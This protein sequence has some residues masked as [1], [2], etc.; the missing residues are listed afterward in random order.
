M[1]TFNLGDGLVV[2]VVAMIVV[3]AVLAS[4]WFLVELVHKLVGEPAAVASAPV[5]REENLQ[6]VLANP[7]VDEQRAKVAAITALI[8]A[9]ESHPSKKFEIVDVTRIK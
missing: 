7:G 6:P 4:L 3:F 1:G 8:A 5:Q 2:T 9:Y